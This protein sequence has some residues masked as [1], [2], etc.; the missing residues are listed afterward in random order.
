M[1]Y[2]IDENHKPFGVF[3]FNGSLIFASIHAHLEES[4]SRRDDLESLG[5]SM[6]FLINIKYLSW[7][8][9]TDKTEILNAKLKF[10]EE[11]PND[12]IWP[13]WKFLKEI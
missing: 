3:N 5:Y 9:L 7:L 13:I 2:I 1:D 11:E 12:D 8:E 4:L 6:I 10:L